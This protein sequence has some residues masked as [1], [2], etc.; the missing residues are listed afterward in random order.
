MKKIILDLSY[1]SDDFI[2]LT[3]ELDWIYKR[4]MTFISTS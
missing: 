2:I 1:M 3:D 4:G